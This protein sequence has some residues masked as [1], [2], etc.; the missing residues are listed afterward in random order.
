MISVSIRGIGLPLLGY[1]KG[2]TLKDGVGKTE[3]MS[4]LIRSLR[5]RLPVLNPSI[6]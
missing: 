6:R 5:L 4:L 1:W 2:R 3:L